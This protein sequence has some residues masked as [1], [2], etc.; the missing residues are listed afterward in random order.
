[1]KAKLLYILCAFGCFCCW[2]SFYDLTVFTYFRYWVGPLLTE[3][4]VDISADRVNPENEG[5]IVQCEGELQ[6]LDT[7]RDPVYKLELK[8]LKLKRFVETTRT[9]E[10]QQGYLTPMEFCSSGQN[11][12]VGAYGLTNLNEDTGVCISRSV[13]LTEENIPDFLRGRATLHE[14][15]IH[16]AEEDG[17]T[18]K[19]SFWSEC[20]EPQLR[21]HFQGRQ[22]GDSIELMRFTTMGHAS[23]LIESY[24]FRRG[25][26]PSLG[27]VCLRVG[28]AFSMALLSAFFCL[29]FICKLF[30]K[31]VPK[32]V[33]VT[34]LLLALQGTLLVFIWEWRRL[35]PDWTEY[36]GYNLAKA[37]Q[38]LSFCEQALTICRMG[39]ALTLIYLVIVA[40]CRRFRSNKLTQ[41]VNM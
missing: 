25:L 34:F 41:R 12:R 16:I 11:F 4:I 14:G 37:A 26:M 7:L 28:F 30:T 18:S 36:C 19:V 10:S 38:C 31:K 3:P 33:I 6:G 27:D 20:A 1:M 24:N 22:K 23:Q 29:Y 35:L 32:N 15:D 40:L 17:S 2:A 9:G 13:W 39:L 5:K 8:G 21:G